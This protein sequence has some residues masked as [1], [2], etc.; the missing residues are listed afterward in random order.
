LNLT[1]SCVPG[2]TTFILVHLLVILNFNPAFTHYITLIITAG[3][4]LFPPGIFAWTGVNKTQ[5]MGLGLSPKTYV[6]K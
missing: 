3:E 1:I 2:C 6:L 5:I 4:C